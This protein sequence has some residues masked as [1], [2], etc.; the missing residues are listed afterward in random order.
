MGKMLN[1]QNLC[2]QVVVV[3]ILVRIGLLQRLKSSGFKGWKLNF[4][5]HNSPN[6]YSPG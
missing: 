5:L 4:L 2:F 6:L 3:S 1:G